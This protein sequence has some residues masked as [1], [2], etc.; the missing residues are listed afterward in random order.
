MQRR[1]GVMG[2]AGQAAKAEV[3][4]ALHRGSPLLL[5]ANPRDA[6]E[7]AIGR[8]EMPRFMAER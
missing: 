5:M 6:V 8:P 4:R 7:P 2:G 3:V 1:G